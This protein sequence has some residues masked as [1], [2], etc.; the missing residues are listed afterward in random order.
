MGVAAVI[1]VGAFVVLRKQQ[2]S[3]P[4]P[5]ETPKVDPV[6]QRRQEEW[7]AQQKERERQKSIRVLRQKLE[8]VDRQI[9]SNKERLKDAY[10]WTRDRDQAEA[11]ELAMERAR[12]V[13]ELAGFGEDP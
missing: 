3:R 1:L 4:P 5:T 6:V 9:A 11:K 12:I 10:S 2:D 13:A 7:E 8:R